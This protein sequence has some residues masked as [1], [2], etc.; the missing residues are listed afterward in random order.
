MRSEEFEQ[1]YHDIFTKYKEASDIIL[2]LI[3]NNKVLSENLDYLQ[4]GYNK[5]ITE[6]KDESGQF[7]LGQQHS[8]KVQTGLVQELKALLDILS[9]G[10]ILTETG[11]LRSFEALQKITH[12]CEKYQ[13][14][15]KVLEQ[16][17]EGHN[18]PLESENSQHSLREISNIVEVSADKRMD[19]QN[20]SKHEGLNISRSE[21]PVLFKLKRKLENS[22]FKVRQLQ[23]EKNELN[24]MLRGLTE[25]VR[26]W[27][28]A[29]GM[30]D[31]EYQKT[32]DEKEHV[33]R[34]KDELL[35]RREDL[36]KN[37]EESL[38][39][40]ELLL[41]EK[42]E[43]SLRQN[44]ELNELLGRDMSFN[45]VL[46]EKSESIRELTRQKHE[47]CQRL[48]EINQFSVTVKKELAEKTR[49]LNHK[50]GLLNALRADMLLKDQ[51]LD[52]KEHEIQDKFEEIYRLE[53]AVSFREQELSHLRSENNNLRTQVIDFKEQSLRGEHG[54]GMPP[55][56]RMSHNETAYHT[57][58]NKTYNRGN[59][60]WDSNLNGLSGMR[61]ERFSVPTMRRG[62][63][64]PRSSSGRPEGQA[65]FNDDDDVSIRM[66]KEKNVLLTIENKELFEKLNKLN[67]LI[68]YNKTLEQEIGILKANNVSR[69]G[70]FDTSSK[71]YLD[72][73]AGRTQTETECFDMG[74]IEK[75][76]QLPDDYKRDKEVLKHLRENIKDETTVQ[77]VEKYKAKTKKVFQKRVKELEM[78]LRF[79]DQ[80]S[81]GYNFD[82]L[83]YTICS[84]QDEAEIADDKKTYSKLNYLVEGMLEKNGNLKGFVESMAKRIEDLYIRNYNLN[85]L[86]GSFIK[87][88]TI[89]GLESRDQDFF[90]QLGSVPE[91]EDLSKLDIPELISH[92][93][94]MEVVN[95]SANSNNAKFF[96]VLTTVKPSINIL[97]NYLSK[98]P[99]Q[100]NLGKLTSF[101][102]SAKAEDYITAKSDK[103]KEVETLYL[104]L[105]EIINKNDKTQNSLPDYVKGYIQTY[106]NIYATVMNEAQSVI[107]FATNLVNG[108]GVSQLSEG[109]PDVSGNFEGDNTQTNSKLSAFHGVSQSVSLSAGK[110][111]LKEEKNSSNLRDTRSQFVLNNRSVNISGNSSPERIRFY[112]KSNTYTPTKQEKNE[113]DQLDI[114]VQS[115]RI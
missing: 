101:S 83:T 20:K 33:I 45:A 96:K 34:K 103:L 70:L 78:L 25:E 92:F 95:Q 49:D 79:I 17:I 31:N 44:E 28:E 69:S 56:G 109:P 46:E 29:A 111:M 110:T 82:R 90:E 80:K 89:N 106:N 97:L 85:I 21:S 59:E 27:K 77:F 81:K 114:W 64:R 107:T 68:S 60:K 55:I 115:S 66:L 14:Q 63:T 7:V 16:L 84:I 4:K 104:K 15:F 36:L 26:D 43:L 39:K 9:Q 108:C 19:Q 38:Q 86:L 13:N 12:E 72:T 24:K 53:K 75:C 73:E 10:N 67:E 87:T 62:E 105:I 112:S 76:L 2:Q 37:T 18:G 35:K 65:E 54:Y 91:F 40:T 99:A 50:N 102:F 74:Y 42:E 51:D 58:G 93:N 71:V 23:E 6:R 41:I 32:I 57:P 47:L 11:Q 1:K 88:S 94:E 22:E 3:D 113:N 100:N 61:G 5:L 8:Q 98:N 52:V 30:I 48:D